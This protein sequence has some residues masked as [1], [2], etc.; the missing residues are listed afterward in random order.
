MVSSTHGSAMATSADVTTI[1]APPLGAAA[2]RRGRSGWRMLVHLYRHDVLGM[3]GL[4]ILLTMAVLGIIAPLIATYPT[5][6]GPV[7]WANLPPQPY[8]P[9]GTDELGR[10]IWDQAIYGIRSSF[11]V[12]A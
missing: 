2:P 6:H 11:Y 1:A 5:S 10:S 4:V 12:A 9:F 3:I 8:F 7:K